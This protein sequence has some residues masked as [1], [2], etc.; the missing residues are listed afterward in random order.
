MQLAFRA[1]IQILRAV[2]IV[3]VLIYH[4]WPSALPAGLLG[5][6]LFFVVSGFLM[7]YLYGD[8][9]QM[10]ARDFWLRRGR[11][12]LPAYYVTILLT[13]VAS[14]LI[15][16]PHE[17]REVGDASIA[18]AMLLPNFNYWLSASYFN[19]DT[20]RPLLHL[21]SLGVEAQFYLVFPLIAWFW[22]KARW[23]V[24]VA[25]AGSLAICMVMTVV[26]AKTSFFLLP[27]RLWEFLFGVLAA[28][29][30]LSPIGP[31]LTNRSWIGGVALVA[32]VAVM[33]IPMHGD[34]HPGLW[35]VV[36]CSL[37]VIVLLF[38]LPW[39]SS[40]AGGALK[41]VGDYSYSLYL[42]HFPV[43]LLFFYASFSGMVGRHRSW[44]ALIALLIII[45]LTFIMH[46]TLERPRRKGAAN[47]GAF[48]MTQAALAALCIV[49][50]YGLRP[51]L[52]LRFDP[53]ERAIFQGAD[54]KGIF[55]CGKLARIV[56]P[57]ARSCRL[58]GGRDPILLVGD[59]HADAIKS[60]IVDEASDEGREVWLMV[61]NCTVGSRDCAPET[62][63]EEVQ[64]RG[65]TTVMVQA[66]AKN[67]D[68]DGINALYALSKVRG[69]EVVVLGPTPDWDR[70][71]PQMLYEAR[72]GK[73]LQRISLE[74]MEARDARVLAG[75]SAPIVPLA[76]FI[77]KPDCAHTIDGRPT[78]YDDDHMSLSGAQLVRPA[79]RE[80]LDIARGLPTDRTKLP[81]LEGILPPD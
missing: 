56:A 21:W 72:S 5:V 43:I 11:R 29:V 69:F 4:L 50:V 52:L 42:V 57:T 9:S 67:I 25:A 31:N 73:P 13:L 20:F 71:V 62:I 65:I 55:R 77:C 48:A 2:A 35:A 32:L 18:S 7:A 30:A 16:L 51:L 1:D 6:D 37:T 41:V 59:S 78:Y 54:D 36:T 64:R 17:L 66:A 22:R 14:A 38:G 27:F 24:M 33:G 26:S 12:I 45:V 68:V 19:G 47:P 8:M 53:V 81:L 70:R 75:V 74:D 60:A 28:K 49:S 76:P 44:D 79:V 23:T 63:A 34:Q 80:A 15:V 40:A 61:Q 58:V 39:T 3:G 10:R 46:H